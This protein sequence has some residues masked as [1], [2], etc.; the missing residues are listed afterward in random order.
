MI[1]GTA[2]TLSGEW[3]SGDPLAGGTLLRPA[4]AVSAQFAV[5]VP[6]PTAI[7]L[8]GSVLL[9]GSGLGLLWLSQRQR[10][11]VQQLGAGPR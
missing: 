6:A 3:W 5:L 4:D 1:A 9:L 8:P 11:K 7:P 10:Q 2:P